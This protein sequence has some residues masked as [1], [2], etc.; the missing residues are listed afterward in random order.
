MLILLV[1]AILL[2]F[3]PSKIPE[4][5]KSIGLAVREFKRAAEGEYVEEAEV[6]KATSSSATDEELK[7]LAKKLGISTEGKSAEELKKEIIEVAKKEGLLGNEK[8]EA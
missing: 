4:L 5:A 7:A 6:K 2:I 8:G 1:F 3:G